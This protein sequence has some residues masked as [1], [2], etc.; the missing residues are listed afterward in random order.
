M[1]VSKTPVDIGWAKIPCC[2]T[3][4]LDVRR[5]GCSSKATE[6]PVDGY[7][8]PSST[9]ASHAKWCPVPKSVI[10]SRQHPLCCLHYAER[11]MCAFRS[12]WTNAFSVYIGGTGLEYR[13]CFILLTSFKYFC[14]VGFDSNCSR[15]CD[16]LDIALSETI[17]KPLWRVNTV[18]ANLH[19]D[20]YMYARQLISN[21]CKILSQ[22][23]SN[24]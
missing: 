21:M 18:L 22:C 3:E 8:S 16:G 10:Y 4:F 12:G 5:H 19:M 11:Q 23:C 1:N 7:V 20:V 14:I 2:K 6:R 24:D 17:V 13:R 9:T 15:F